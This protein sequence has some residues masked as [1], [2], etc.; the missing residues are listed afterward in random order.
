LTTPDNPTS[1][2]KAL[3]APGAFVFTQEDRDRM[4][5]ADELRG[6]V[7]LEIA[8][9]GNPFVSC[10]CNAL[11]VG[12]SSTN[13]IDLYSAHECPDGPKETPPAEVRYT[14]PLPWQAYVFSSRTLGI[15]MVIAA[16]VY[17]L[18][19]PVVAK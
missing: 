2:A 9:N 17:F 3:P 12:D 6:Q 10:T 18:I 11:F 19:A 13:V 7:L 15:L 8:N 16:I 1:L 14:E 5:R 4:A